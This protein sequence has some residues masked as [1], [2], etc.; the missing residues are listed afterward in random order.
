VRQR[1]SESVA[2]RNEGGGG[3]YPA[4]EGGSSVLGVSALLGAPAVCG[5][6]DH[7]QEAGSSID[8]GP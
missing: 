2:T 5:G 7:K 4:I 6:A 3:A 8:E 1:P